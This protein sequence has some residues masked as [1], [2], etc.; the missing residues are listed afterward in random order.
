MSYLLKSKP[1]YEIKAK[2][3]SVVG[4]F[5]FLSLFGWLFPN[6]TRELSFTI[7]RPLW[8]VSSLISSP[9]GK[10]TNY[11]SFKNTLIREK[12]VLEEELRALRLRDIDRELLFKE[13]EE[14]RKQLGRNPSPDL[15]ISR[16]LSKPPKSPYDTLVIDVGSLHNVTVGNNVYLGESIIVG[17]IKEVTEETS[18]VELF[19]NGDLKQEA[20]LLRTG[21]SF[22]L[23][24]RGGANFQIEVP[25]DTDIALGDVFGYPGFS[26]N[27]LGNVYHID[28]SSKGSFKT[29]YLKVPGNIFQTQWV[30]VEN[31]QI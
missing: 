15:V 8:R 29:V 27:V 23:V 30:F 2:V 5:V 24:G 13:N 20:I 16:V 10:I 21:V 31:S 12:L 26:S 7:A 19:S 11:F 14:L 18:V 28:D 25:K 9:F 6:F 17:K 1:R 4:V 22:T 3:V